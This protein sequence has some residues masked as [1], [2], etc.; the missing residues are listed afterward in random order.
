MEQ[1]NEILESAIYAPYAA[2]ATGLPLSDVRKVFVFSTGTP[3]M[4]SAKEILLSAIAS[5]ALK[6]NIVLKIFPFLNKKMKSFSNRL[7]SISRNGIP[8]LIDGSYFVVIAERKGF[9]PNEKQS[10]SHVIQNMWLTATKFNIGFQ[11]L[12]ATGIL[13][14]NSRFLKLLNLPKNKYH[15]EGC[16]IGISKQ[17]TE[18][19]K[20]F[21]LDEFVSWIS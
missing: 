4:E 15:L 6:I 1:V 5:N 12:S 10:L 11:L 2:A 3:S 8:S 13:S 19:R 18:E 21:Q 7:N 20:E 16:V 14:N 17:Q 9:P